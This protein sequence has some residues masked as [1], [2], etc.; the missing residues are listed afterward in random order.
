MSDQERKNKI[1]D[2]IKKAMKL[3]ERGVGGEAENASRIV[4]KMMAE[5]NILEAEL[6]ER[7]EASDDTIG[8][9]RTKEVGTP[10][11]QR[12]LMG[13]V[14]RHCNCRFAYTKGGGGVLV[15]YSHDVAVAEY[16]YV[17][18]SREIAKRARSYVRVELD[19]EW[20]D[21]GDKRRMG[22]EF[23]VNAVS[24]FR[25]KLAEIR[26]DQRA[27]WDTEGND[28]QFALVQSRKNEV[29][30]YVKENT[31]WSSGRHSTSYGHNSDGRAAGR[32]ISIH[33]GLNGST[34]GGGKIIS[35]SRRLT[36]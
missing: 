12:N 22:N 1:I 6:K 7:G 13:V 18:A 9:H 2:R 4:A 14:A 34:G 29:A 28:Q 33:Q 16:L 17:I 11:W 10:Q 35:R 31:N 15:G 27:E 30:E 20:Y 5:H 8:K 3:A 19:D 32:S 25:E 23:K 24:G 36:G 21:M 26:R